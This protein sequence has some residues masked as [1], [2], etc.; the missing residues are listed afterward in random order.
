MMRHRQSDG[1]Q[2]I[3]Q[4]DRGYRFQGDRYFCFYIQKANHIEDRKKNR[5]T[6]KKKE[7]LPWNSKST[8]KGNEYNSQQERRK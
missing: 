3:Q 5:N 1:Q 4:I 8:F 6:R 7:R 2:A